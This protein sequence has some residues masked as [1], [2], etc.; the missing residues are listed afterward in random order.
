M[1]IRFERPARDADVHSDRTNG[2]MPA[3]SGARWRD[4]ALVAYGRSF[5]H[6]AKV[7]IVQWLVRRIVAGRVLVR[8]A[9]GAIVAIEPADYTGWAIF[10]HGHYEPASLRLALRIM[11]GDPG[12]FVDVGANFG[13]YTC[14]VA[15]IA[16]CSVVAI[17]PDCENCTKLRRNVELGNLRNVGVFNGAVG[18]QADIL[19]T[20]KRARG[21]SGTVA[22]RTDDQQPDAPTDW[23]ATVPLDAL[24]KRIA[25]PP[26]RPVLIKIDV[27]GLE[28]EV[29]AGLDFEGPFRPRNILMEFDLQL[30]ERG[31]GS[32]DVM[33]A[34]FHARDYEILD[35][36]GRPLRDP[37]VLPEN[38]V[39]VR[40]T[41]SAVR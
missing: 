28:P 29:L 4:A 11:A 23:V 40:E 21:N 7:R 19:P 20:I 3:S 10:R 2:Y 32:F 16:G 38:N 25:N 37:T 34:F 27:E 22:I 14:A 6:P 36:F 9:A 13:W 12:L 30:S 26:T 35:V 24:L 41:V 18:A 5:E 17:E 31:W 8:Y 39:W 33:Q 1:R 15:A